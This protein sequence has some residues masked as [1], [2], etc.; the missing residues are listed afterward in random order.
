V[1]S[2][3]KTD[4]VASILPTRFSVDIPESLSYGDISNARVDGNSLSGN[5]IYANLRLFI[6][7]G[8]IS[9]QTIEQ[10]IH[11]I[12]KY[13]ID[14]PMELKFRSNW[15]NRFKFIK[16]EEMVFAEGRTWDY[17]LNA[18][19]SQDSILAFQLYWNRHP[20]EGVAIMKVYDMNRQLGEFFRD[21]MYKTEYSEAD[22][23]FEKKMSISVTR[24]IL[25]L[26]HK[27]A[28]D[29][30]KMFA[31]KKGNEVH[32]YGNT[33]HPNIWLVDEDFSE[34]RNYAFVGKANIKYD[35][36]VA[37][38]SLPPSSVTTD[39][40]L[41]DVYSVYDVIKGEV[42]SAYDIVIEPGGF[43]DQLYQVYFANTAAPGYFMKPIGFV[44]CGSVI[45]NHAGFTQ[46]FINLSG[47]KPFVPS[48]VKD[49]TIPFNN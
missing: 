29:K 42:E 6:R 39:V 3:D 2:C 13:G 10:I 37:T 4:E 40:G 28:I 46:E 34:G 36:G 45:P 38:I 5:L 21:W 8:E 16:I 43:L 12:R 15:D 9:A 19:D 32:L 20:I 33:N 35:I 30:L 11:G 1:G 41:A 48:S 47:L 22:V 44:S 23:S 14:K 18:W 24:P 31:G 25:Q 27:W 17:G 26:D 7:I 49:L